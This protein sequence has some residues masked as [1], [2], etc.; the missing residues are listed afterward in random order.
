MNKKVFN[1]RSKTHWVSAA[2]TVSGALLMFAPGLEGALPPSAFAWTLFG[3]GVVNHILRNV[4][5]TDIEAK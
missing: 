2:T 4:T 1:P 3:L 5:S